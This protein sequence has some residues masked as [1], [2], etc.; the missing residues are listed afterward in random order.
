MELSG[1]GRACSG[2]AEA[3]QRAVVYVIGEQPN[4]VARNRPVA[5]SCRIHTKSPIQGSNPA[6]ASAK[7]TTRV[8]RAADRPRPPAAYEP[9]A[10]AMRVVYFRIA[11]FS[12]VWIPW[13][14]H[15]LREDRRGG[16]RASLA[17][18]PAWNRTALLAAIL[19]VS[20][21]RRLGPPGVPAVMP[22]RKCQGRR[23]EPA[24]GRPNRSQYV[25]IRARESLKPR[26]SHSILVPIS[27]ARSQPRIFEMCSRRR[28]ELYEIS[29]VTGSRSHPSH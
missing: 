8:A 3:A 29:T 7:S 1:Q 12:V 21:R 6:S 23:H 15:I 20:P 25:E 28:E 14:R 10:V 26:T 9:P 11:D 24:L 18:V 13:W 5:A 4:L 19:M 2:S 27:S 17:T 22:H 16:L